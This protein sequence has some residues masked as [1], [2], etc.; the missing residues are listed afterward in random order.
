MDA[1]PN[2]ILGEVAYFLSRHDLLTLRFVERRFKDVVTRR[3]FNRLVTHD[4]FSSLL[5]FYV[6]VEECTDNMILDAVETIVFDGKDTDHFEMGADS[7][8]DLIEKSF[9]LL[10][11]FPNLTALSLDFFPESAPDES[12]VYLTY[13][14][15]VQLAFWNSIAQHPLPNLR[16]LH[17]GSMVSYFPRRLDDDADPFRDL[18]RPLTS[19]SLYVVSVFQ[20]RRLPSEILDFNYNI[21]RMLQV[22]T[23]ITSLDL[24]TSD[25][26]GPS[27]PFGFEHYT[28]PALRSLRLHQIIF[29]ALPE[30]EIPPL[31]PVIFGQ[32]PTGEVL[33]LN[34]RSVLRRLELCD[35]V[36]A[37]PD[38]AWDRVFRRFQ[39][40]LT[41]L[42]EF[43]WTIKRG[44]PEQHFLYAR[45]K[46]QHHTYTLLQLDE[47]GPDDPQD[48]AALDSLQSAVLL[49]RNNTSS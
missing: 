5:K 33:I 41:A 43:T 22:G 39:H 24:G 42:V 14:V 49:R 48:V 7:T 6:L 23:N 36:A 26:L 31:D 45:A 29:P 47:S 32:R 2:E 1:L 16:S 11:R 37:A 19:L 4:S 20:M 35:C 17:I 34:H 12:G 8:I 38:G 46:A 30:D 9:C 21:T 18:F 3:A 27:L 25:F 44:H 10:Y 13:Y 40:H 28:F 15:E